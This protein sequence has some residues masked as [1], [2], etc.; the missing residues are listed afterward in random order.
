MLPR[1]REILKAIR[2]LSR[3]SDKVTLKVISGKTHIPK[4]EVEYFCGRLV[5]NGYIVGH[6]LHGYALTEKAMN[7]LEQMAIISRQIEER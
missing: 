7:L 5:E 1:E 4:S 2:A 6:R 3:E